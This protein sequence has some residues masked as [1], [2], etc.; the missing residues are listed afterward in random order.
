VDQGSFQRSDR[1]SGWRLRSATAT[2]RRHD[3]T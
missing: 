3:T 2:R 1:G